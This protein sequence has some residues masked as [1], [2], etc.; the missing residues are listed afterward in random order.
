MGIGAF[1]P[2][3]VFT[4]PP[5]I[6]YNA[7][8]KEQTLL[9][10]R[11]VYQQSA[12]RIEWRF[13]FRIEWERLETKAAEPREGGPAPLCPEREKGPELGKSSCVAG[14]DVV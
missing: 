14:V 1:L 2:I 9:F 6:V 12:E 10:S 5:Y 7:I 13:G 11:A 8:E 4:G 3:A